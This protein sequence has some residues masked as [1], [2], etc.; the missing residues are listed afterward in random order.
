MILKFRKSLLRYTLDFHTANV[1]E[2]IKFH[3]N[4][5]GTGITPYENLFPA[6]SLLPSAGHSEKVNRYELK[7][8]EVTK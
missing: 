4:K 6:D 7:F 1:S 3:A 5:V 8:H 2:D